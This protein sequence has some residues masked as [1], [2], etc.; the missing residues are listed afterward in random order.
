M[1]FKPLAELSHRRADIGARLEGGNEGVQ[2]LVVEQCSNQ[3]LASFRDLDHEREERFFLLA[4]MRHA[5]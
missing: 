1:R 2:V 3:Q 4:E 5:R